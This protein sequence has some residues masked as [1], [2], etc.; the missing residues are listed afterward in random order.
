MPVCSA[1]SRDTPTE[2]RSASPS[3]DQRQGPHRHRPTERAARNL[4]AGAGRSCSSC[5]V[6][7]H[8]T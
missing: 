8:R 6:R 7:A 3:D 2:K 5:S 4:A 1:R